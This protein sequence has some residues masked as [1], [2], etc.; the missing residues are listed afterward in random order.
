M[1]QIRENSWADEALKRFFDEL[2]VEFRI[3]RRLG[4]FYI[5]GWHPI[6][7]WPQKALRPS[8]MQG[9]LAD[10]QDRGA[11][12]EDILVLTHYLSKPQQRFL[13]EH[14]I[15]YLDLAGNAYVRQ[16]SNLIF[17]EGRSQKDIVQLDEEQFFTPAFMRLAFAWL[18]RPEMLTMSYREQEKLS[19]VAKATIS[20][21]IPKLAQAGYAKRNKAGVWYWKDISE[22]AVRWIEAY[23]EILRPQLELGRYKLPH[24]KQYDQWQELWKGNPELQWGGETAGYLLTHFIQPAIYTLYSRLTKVE[25]MKHLRLIPDTKGP[26]HLLKSFWPRELT[27]E[28]PQ[29]QVTPLLVYA[30]LLTSRDSRNHQI[31]DIIYERYL[32]DKL[33][34]IRERG[35]LEGV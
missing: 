18:V 1:F 13:R 8:Q 16:G 24:N 3:D 10:I 28:M 32:K 35:V 33:P 19:G 14:Q 4:Q 26:V 30:D 12:T 21:H 6:R 17:I 27:L 11:D 9:L 25:S 23:P 29:E 15:P 34:G 20:E 7:I 5:E 31:A 2:D 22:L